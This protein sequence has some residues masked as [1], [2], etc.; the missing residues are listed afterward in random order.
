MQ[1]I[2]ELGTIYIHSITL[3]LSDPAG[4]IGPLE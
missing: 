2:I 4:E 3:D 1:V